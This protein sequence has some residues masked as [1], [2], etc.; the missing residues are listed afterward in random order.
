[1][2]LCVG[3]CRFRLVSIRTPNTDTNTSTSII[4]ERFCNHIPRT[5]HTQYT[6]NTNTIHTH[7][8]TLHTTLTRTRNNTKTTH[9]TLS[10]THTT[11]ANNTRTQHVHTH[12]RTRRWISSIRQTVRVLDILK[13]AEAANEV[14]A[15]VLFV[16][17]VVVCFCSF[18]CLFVCLFVCTNAQ[19]HNET[20]ANTLTRTLNQTYTNTL[21]HAQLQA[22][23][24]TPSHKQTSNSR[25][26]WHTYT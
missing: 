26:H 15:G 9:T 16:C 13:Q 6:H 4:R 3:L 21:P 11:H 14:P 22:N 12:T 24:Q 25:T 23:K 8:H 18:A 20:Q 19:T 10:R 5:T 7:T 17:W 1:V 2:S